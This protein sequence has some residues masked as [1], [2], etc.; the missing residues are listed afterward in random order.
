MMATIRGA[1]TKGQRKGVT[2]IE[3]PVHPESDPKTCTEWRVIDVPSEVV[4][5]LQRRNRIHF[6]QAHG[7]P[8]T[9]PPLSTDLGFCGD[10]RGTDDILNGRYDSSQFRE[11]VQLLI[12]QNPTYPTISEAEFIGKLKVWKESTTTSPSGLHLDH[13]KAQ[14]LIARHKYSE[15]ED[16][17][18][19]NATGGDTYSSNRDEWNHMQ[20]ELRTFHLTLLNYALERGYSYSRWHSI[21]N[22]I[23]F[24][25]EDNVRIHRTRVI[26]IYEADLN[27]MLGLKWRVALYQAEALKILNDGQ[28]GSRPRR[29]AV[30]PVMIEELQFEISRISR[31]MFLQTNYNATAC[32]DRIILQYQT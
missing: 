23:L 32:Y 30:D 28:Y 5:H 1:R 21:T 26:H 6:G 12:A 17:E 10:L 18:S 8:F 3:I 11:N 7:T 27:L 15:N 29:N 24:K 2:S 13:Y 31:R 25:D 14:A 19:E 22:M 16:T 9:I 20:Q 4:G